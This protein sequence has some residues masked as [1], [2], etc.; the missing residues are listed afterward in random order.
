[1]DKTDIAHLEV[2]SFA[3]LASKDQ[4]ELNK[5]LDACRKQGFFYLDLAGSNV[6]HGLHQRLKA[7]SLMKDWFDRPNEEKMKL[8]KDSVTNGLVF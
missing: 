8:H 4:T 6:S 5:L 2:L 1:M 7:L 3:K